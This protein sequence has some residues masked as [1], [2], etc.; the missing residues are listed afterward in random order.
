[1]SKSGTNEA[2]QS[3]NIPKSEEDLA[4]Q[5]LTAVS[6]GDE[7][8]MERLFSFQPEPDAELE[9]EDDSEEDSDSEEAKNAS[10]KGSEDDEA[11]DASEEESEEEE[12]R[13][14]TQE[15]PNPVADRIAQLEQQLANATAAVGR[16]ASTQSR[17]A[18]LERQLKQQKARPEEAEKDA[19]DSEKRLRDR[20]AKL[21]EIDP[22]TAE[23]LETMLE[24]R[25]KTSEAKDQ[26][27]ESA[28]DDELQE[29]YYKLLEVHP[30]AE[31]VFKH[32]SWYAWK[33][34]LTPEQA[35]WANSSRAQH[36][37]AAMD[38][39]KQY[40]Q[41]FVQAQD[42]SDAG[43][44]SPKDD[45]VDAT[46]QAREQKLKRS[47]D[48]SDKPVKKQPKFD[49]SQFFSEAYEKIAKEAGIVY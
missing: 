20:I 48:S 41:G 44:P 29:E 36:V 28:Q 11:A 26:N 13:S 30:D 37:A 22:D 24:Q 15:D 38:A 19:D 31:A 14:T 47:A 21:K 40:M 3:L 7:E 27:Q 12:G 42:K 35:A 9:E 4:D 10:D 5:I 39:Y 1:M 6:E 16:M 23:I 25:P 33:N 46:K 17:L 34:T 8:E 18:Q 45:V 32:P 43:R 2:E 49:E